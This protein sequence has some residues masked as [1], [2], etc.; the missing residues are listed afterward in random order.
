[1]I[2]VSFL[3]TFIVSIVLGGEGFLMAD[4]VFLVNSLCNIDFT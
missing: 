4:F 1:M 2:S 3:D